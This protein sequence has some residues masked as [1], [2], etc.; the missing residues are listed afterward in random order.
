MQPNHQLIPGFIIEKYALGELRGSF[1]GAALFVDLSGFSNIADTLAAHGD[2]GAEA[3]A[4]MIR[5]MFEPLVNAV[6]AQGGFVAGYAGD[7]F[8]AFFEAGQDPAEAVRRCLSSAVAMQAHAAAHATVS[9]EYGIFPLHIKVGIGFGQT[10]WQIFKSKD[11]AHATFW[12]RGG[13]LD[14]AVQSEENARPGHIVMDA[15]SYDLVKEFAQARSF[16]AYYLLE[17]I[18]SDLP[19]PLRFTP[20]KPAAEFAGLFFPESILALPVTGEFRH[21]INVFVD[22]PTSISDEALVAPFMETV[23]ALQEKYGGYFLRPDLGDKGFNLLMMWGAPLAH[24]NDI[25]RALDFVLELAKRTRLPLR[26]GISY[27][28]AYAGFIGAGLREDYTAYGWGVNLAARLME[29]AGEGEYWVD[30]E[31][32]RRAGKY[33]EFAELGEMQYKGFAEKQPTFALKKR[34]DAA[35]IAYD[36]EMFGRSGEL[37]TLASFVEPLR[38]GDFAGVMVIK[39]DAGIGKSRLVHEFQYSEVFDD[40]QANW[41]VCHTDEIIRQPFHPLIHWLRARFGYVDGFPDQINLESFKKKMK[42]L[43]ARLP[44]AALA[45][46]LE[47]TSSMLSALLSMEEPDSLYAR[48]DAK[49]R[50]E[51]IIIALSNL[52]KA[53]SL[54]QPLILF[55][56][57]THWLDEETGAFLAAF[58]P[59]LLADPEKQYPIAII[60]TQ[61]LEGDSIRMMDEVAMY[62]IRLGKLSSA[63]MRAFAREMLGAPIDP[64]LEK[65]LDERADGNPFFA[66]QIL[67]YLQEQDLVAFNAKNTACAVTG[68][69]TALPGDVR[70]VMVARID[71]LAARVRDTVQ[72]ASVL[73][74]DFVLDVL[75]A[76]LRNPYQVAEDVGEAEK[77]G[78]WMPLS[79][80][81]YIFRHALLRDAAYS[82]QLAARQT[83]LHALAVEA[84]EQVYADELEPHYAEIAYHAEKAGLRDKALHYL[85]LS[86]DAAL[87]AYLNAQAID[88]LNRIHALLDPGDLRGRFEI[89]YKR[90]EAYYRTS[91]RDALDADLTELERIAED[92]GDDKLRGRAHTRRGFFHVTQGDNSAAIESCLKAVAYARAQNDTDTLLE[93]FSVMPMCYLRMG[94][95]EES[96]RVAEETL[97][98]AQAAGNRKAEAGAYTMLG[99]A[100][101]EKDGPSSA[102]PYQHKAVEIAGEIRE[103]NLEGKALGNLANTIALSQGDYHTALGYYEQAWAVLHELGDR[104]SEGI[105]LT[106]LGW[107]CSMLGNYEEAKDY[108]ARALTISRATAN[109]H[110]EIFAMI[111]LAACAVGGRNPGIAIDWA[112]RAHA[113]AERHANPAGQA[114]AF[115][116]MGHGFLLN[117]QYL[118]AREV[119]NRS[120][121]IRE[122]LQTPVLIVEAQAA[123]AQVAFQNRNPAGALKEIEPALAY[124]EKDP[125]FEG[126]EEPLRIYLVCCQILK[127]NKDPRFNGALEKARALLEAQ[128]VKLPDENTR[129]LFIENVPWRKTLRELIEETA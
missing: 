15:R 122:Q 9:T 62:G 2:H 41:V 92:L 69:E 127:E 13:S 116:H 35:Q 51:N 4:K 14:N 48:L 25:N 117:G 53:E 82:M 86:A 94:R 22:I 90:A 91:Q 112:E 85:N 88:N 123:L 42:D 38:K 108:H 28:L 20:P 10:R 29:H 39:G 18:K 34:R 75:S 16:G 6:Y 76:M 87:Q 63:S 54:L 61:R 31:I 128:A 83:L 44:D 102:L 124:M 11:G 111:N 21:V 37:A 84:M 105:M 27:H 113:L 119:L 5:A 19:A 17:Q 97:G 121:S 70:A 57:D 110:L 95:V 101:L 36:G 66:E 59:A 129:R 67:R 77:A 1:D 68:A 8:N 46:E 125:G 107:A 32:A 79:E 45:S 40:L 3:L 23:Y 118:R 71:R 109:K 47:R 93:A 100:V 55:L 120:L 12:F 50:H 56:E 104:Y 78:I 73:G 103:R 30:A 99:L 43:L 115:F 98:L 7:A 60:A 89:T 49:A 126:A 106:N 72:T 65:I 74:R 24:E 58:V 96:V 80:I 26:A 81:D 52:L 64:S 33:F 114:W